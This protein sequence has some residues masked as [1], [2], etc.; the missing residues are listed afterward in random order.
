V[1]TTIDTAE[2]LKKILEAIGYSTSA[3]AE[4]LRWYNPKEDQA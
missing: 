4:I 3:I 2:D 1:N